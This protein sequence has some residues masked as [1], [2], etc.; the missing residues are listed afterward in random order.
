MFKGSLR[1]PSALLALALSMLASQAARAQDATQKTSEQERAA[2]Q[3][4][5][6]PAQTGGTSKQKV[7]WPAPLTPGEKVGGALRGAFL[8]PLPYVASAFTAGVT[9]FNEDRLPH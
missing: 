2:E 1:L 3:Q 4:T 8:N 5:Q 9:Q 6:K 7:N